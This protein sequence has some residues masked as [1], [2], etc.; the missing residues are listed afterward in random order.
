[1]HSPTYCSL[2][3]NL[4]TPPAPVHTVWHEQKKCIRRHVKYMYS[5][6]C[7]V[8]SSISLRAPTQTRSANGWTSMGMWSETPFFLQMWSSQAWLHSPLATH[9]ATDKIKHQ[10]LHTALKYPGPRSMWSP[11]FYNSS[12]KDGDLRIHRK[13]IQVIYLNKDSMLLMKCD[14]LRDSKDNRH[15]GVSWFYLCHI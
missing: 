13:T 6:S 12:S 5:F 7:H 2:K 14:V 3:H 11:L 15:L 9:P 1:M 8:P 4:A 10:R